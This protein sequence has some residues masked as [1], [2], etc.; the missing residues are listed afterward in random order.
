MVILDASNV[1][2]QPQV[3]RVAVVTCI[4]SVHMHHNCRATFSELI[5][6]LN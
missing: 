5:M 4:V 2:L 6:T 1:L 3:Y